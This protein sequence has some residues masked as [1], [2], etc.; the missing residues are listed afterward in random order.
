MSFGVPVVPPETSST[1]MPAG[2]GSGSGRGSASTAA[3]H[4]KGPGS[5]ATSTWRSD[6]VR[7]QTA[8][9]EL[10]VVKAAAAVG[11]DVGDGLGELGE[12][13]DLGLAVGRQC[14]H[15]DGPGAAEGEQQHDELRDVRQLDDDAVAGRDAEVGEAG[16][17]AIG[18][19]V[20]LAVRHPA[21][22]ADQRGAAGVALRP[23]PQQDSQ[24]LATPVARGAVGRGEVVWPGRKPRRRGCCVLWLRHGVP[25][26]RAARCRC[27]MLPLLGSPYLGNPNGTGRS[28]TTGGRVSHEQLTAEDVRA[29]VALALH[30]SPESIDEDQNLIER[31]LDSIRL[32]R[33]AGRWRQAGIEASF[34]ELAERPTL[35][36]W[37]PT[38]DRAQRRRRAPAATPRPAPAAAAVPTPESRE[39]FALA[40]MQH[41]YWVGRSDGQQLGA[42]ARPPLHGVR[43]HR[44]R[45]GAPRPRGGA[46]RRPP[47]DAARALS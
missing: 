16:G 46:R 2:S 4:A 21:A 34:A 7:R 37:S 44:R 8:A 12:V 11:D 14:Q 32:M 9:G 33:L 29:A 26:D 40:L 19:L 39:P 27:T 25:L 5:P 30:E 31:G 41:A 43:R 18:A 24:R 35:G 13:R 47:R 38:A 3:R 10:A 28:A 22:R 36:D 20:E 17:L 15:G 1:A 45:P 42:V 23:S 6:G